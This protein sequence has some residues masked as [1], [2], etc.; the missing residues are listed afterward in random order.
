MIKQAAALLCAWQLRGKGTFVCV[1]SG[2][3]EKGLLQLCSAGHFIW[4]LP[5]EGGRGVVLGGTSIIVLA[6]MGLGLL[7]LTLYNFSKIILK[8]RP[9]VH[10]IQK[11][12]KGTK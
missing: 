11:N 8:S 12:S 7:S 1:T 5:L 2:L 6:D 9:Y 3:G 4:K 10:M